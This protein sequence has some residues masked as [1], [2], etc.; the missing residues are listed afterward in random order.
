VF[1]EGF[2][3]PIDGAERHFQAIDKLLGFEAFML[4]VVAFQKIET[5]SQGCCSHNFSLYDNF[6]LYN[7]NFVALR[8]DL[9]QYV[10]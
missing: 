9:C 2:E 4:L 6:I 1:R 8:I 5:A 3:I 7:E 10:N